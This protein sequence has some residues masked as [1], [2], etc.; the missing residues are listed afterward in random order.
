MKTLL[1]NFILHMSL[2]GTSLSFLTLGTPGSTGFHK[3]NLTME[4]PISYFCD[5]NRLET[6]VYVNMSGM[7]T[8]IS[9]LL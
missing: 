7:H 1:P 8:N 4:P 9:C 3:T 5:P 6:V 2:S